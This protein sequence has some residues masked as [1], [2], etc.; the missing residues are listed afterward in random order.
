[1][2][3]YSLSQ[4]YDTLA[5]ATLV[6]SFVLNRVFD[7]LT[8]R[9]VFADGPA[10]YKLGMFLALLAILAYYYCIGQG[11]RWAQWLFLGL[12][13]VGI[14]VVL[15][16]FRPELGPVGYAPVHVL[17]YV[18]KYAGQGIGAFFIVLS[19]RQAKDQR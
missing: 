12:V 3:P 4:K 8:H 1:M 11:R 5:G 17:A 14:P 7:A 19:L 6:L 13:V 16:G 10:A 9:G 2:T 18:L 15:L